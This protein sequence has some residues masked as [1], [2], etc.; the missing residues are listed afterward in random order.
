MQIFT[1]HMKLGPKEDGAQFSLS[2]PVPFLTHQAAVNFVLD[3]IIRFFWFNGVNY[4]WVNEVLE[5]HDLNPSEFV[6]HGTDDAKKLFQIMKSGEYPDLATDFL[7]E[8]FAR[9]EK[10]DYESFYQITDHEVHE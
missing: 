10:Q 6:G 7:D 8:F 9:R 3:E 5:R 4:P 1:V 2:G